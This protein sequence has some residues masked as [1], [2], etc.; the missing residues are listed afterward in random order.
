M[1]KED[2]YRILLLFKKAVTTRTESLSSFMSPVPCG[3]P[4]PFFYKNTIS[5]IVS[6]NT[7]FPWDKS[8]IAK[9]SDLSNNEISK[10]INF[11]SKTNKIKRKIDKVS[12]V[13]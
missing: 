1:G 13:Q 7:S 6:D 9:I 2:V 10:Q 11:D 5:L 8:F 3:T 12:K 4:A